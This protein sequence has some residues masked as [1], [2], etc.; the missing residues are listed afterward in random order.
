MTHTYDD[1]IGIV[2]TLRR[3]LEM[4]GTPAKTVRMSHHDFDLVLK[5][6]GQPPENPT[7]LGMELRSWDDPVI[8]V[9]TEPKFGRFV[10]GQKLS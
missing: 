10:Q 1:I 6:S 5:E 4:R 3:E 2:T 7:L 9:A 8:Q